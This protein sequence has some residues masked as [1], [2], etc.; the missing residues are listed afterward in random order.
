MGGYALSER[1]LDAGIGSDDAAV[2]ACALRGLAAAMAAGGA[3]RALAIGGSITAGQGTS[4]PQRCGDP[5]PQRLE[6]RLKRSLPLGAA[7]AAGGI[8]SGGGGGGAAA[9]FSQQ[10]PPSVPQQQPNRH[11]D[12][13]V[14]N[15]GF[16]GADM[17]AFAPKVQMKVLP[18]LDEVGGY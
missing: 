9:G 15:Y 17:C 7:G 6:A 8:G 5:F 11:M 18:W 2:A 10:P 13:M 3:V 16:H 14:L 12:H 1:A 4:D